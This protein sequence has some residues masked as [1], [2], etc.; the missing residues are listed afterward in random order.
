MLDLQAP[1]LATRNKQI[2]HCNTPQ[3]IPTPNDVFVCKPSHCERLLGGPNSYQDCIGIIRFRASQ[4][5]IG[6]TIMGI[7]LFIGR[8]VTPYAEKAFAS[9]GCENGKGVKTP[10]W[11]D[12]E[13]VT[14]KTTK[15]RRSPSN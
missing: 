1:G 10:R 3:P 2:L 11:R 8:L 6:A 14:F 15:L 5:G 4:L 9:F 12:Q 7:S 13:V